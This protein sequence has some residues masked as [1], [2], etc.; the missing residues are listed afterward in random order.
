[1]AFESLT[2]KLQNVFKNLRSK[3]RLT[4]EDVKTALKEVKIAL[5]EADVNFRVVKQFVKAVEER[6]IGSDVMNGLNPG[7]MVI[8]IVNEEMVALMGSE[9]TEIQMQPGKSITVIMMCGLQGAGKTTTTAKIAGKLKLKGKKS[10]LVACDVYRPAAI[11]QLQ[12][13][14]EK[15]QVEV[16]SMGENQKPVNIA[17][18]AIEH[19]KKNGHNVVILDTAG[20]LHIDE[21]MMAELQE[22]KE[23]VEVHQSLLV[24]DAM[25]GQ[26]AVTVAKEF[27]EKIGIDGV[28]LSKMDGDTRGGAALS[29]KAVTGKPILYVGMGEKLS[30]L[31]QFYPDRMAGRI[32]GMGDVLSL[33]EKAQE[34]ISIDEEKEKEMAARMKKGKFDFNDYLE[35]MKQM[36]NMGGL[37]SILGMLPGMS[38]QL[39]NLES[40][41]DEKQ[42]AKTEAIIL[43]MTPQER[44]NPKLLNLSR[45]SRIAR[46]AGVEM[47]VVNRFVKQFEQSQK[48]MKQMSGF[49][50]K[51]R[52]GFGGMRFPF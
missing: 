16:F 27:N 33:I 3:G 39:G 44:A 51:R 50:G 47:A 43:S 13:N 15:Q 32:L 17:K 40:M 1:M 42:L 8:K 37:T 19:A 41:I 5:L 22:I 11:K 31:E 26:D 35:S 4:E 10:L 21:D 7:Q 2:D 52:G 20:R 46:G 45:K 9:T 25:T 14:G 49:G 29:V 30:D 48:M 12:V 38:K 18:A 23:Q 6:A 36:R 34:N 24:V 28:I